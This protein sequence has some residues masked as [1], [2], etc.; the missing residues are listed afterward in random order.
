MRILYIS[1]QVFTFS[2][3]FETLFSLLNEL[4]HDVVW[5]ANFTR[6][7]GDIK[8]IPYKVNQIDLVS[9]PLKLTNI[10]ALKQLCKAVDD[11]SIDAI[12]CDTP[13]GS[14]LGR[15][16]GLI[17]KIKPV[18]YVA[19][20][21]LF[22]EGCPFINRT[23]YYWEERIL[24]RVT[25]VLVTIN[26]MDEHAA[27]KMRLRKGGFIGRIH[28]AGVDIDVDCTRNRTLQDVLNLS[29]SIIC[30]SA[31]RIDTNKNIETAIK[32]FCHLKDLDVHY[33]IAGDGDHISK[34]KDLVRELGL[35]ER[36]HFLGYRTDIPLLLNSSDIF[37]LSSVREGLSRSL[38][39][40]MAHGL[41]CVV[42]EARGNRDLIGEDEGGFICSTFDSEQYANS[43]RE[44][45]T[46]R[47]L[48]QAMGDR[49]KKA[50]IPFSRARV[51]EEYRAIFNK[52]LH[53]E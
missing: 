50:I 23:L 53:V 45:V 37:V 2:K 10:R 5:A 31:A 15:L 16:A 27:L 7:N 12:I 24:A 22:Y 14:L 11:S 29:D 4:G 42:S 18:I 43:I 44:L 20:G 28:G 46:S 32:A 40:A 8:S 17:K 30:F 9:K 13:I 26:D 51:V 36:V 35:S 47:A 1:N 41:P 6:F 19:H 25:D 38:M 52:A 21:F 39:E 3:G 49:N 34:L 48:R 33:A